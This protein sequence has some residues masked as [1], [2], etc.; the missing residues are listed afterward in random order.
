MTQPGNGY[1]CDVGYYDW[2]AADNGCFAQGESFDEVRWLRWL[3]KA[4]REGCLFATAPDVLADAKATLERSR[5]Y[6]KQ[7]REMGFPVAFVAQDGLEDSDVPWDV[8]DTLFI[9]GTTAFKFSA[10]AR[11]AIQ[12][13][14]GHGKW[15]HVGRVNSYHRL[16]YCFGIGADSVDGNYLAFGPDINLRKMERW[17][18]QLHQPRSLF[19]WG[20]IQDCPTSTIG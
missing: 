5:P 6:L 14:K 8:F 18:E 12:L 11:E 17:L 20:G 13:A 1:L 7:L 3:D 2:Y 19:E 16:C 4:P 9:G 15:V 10:V